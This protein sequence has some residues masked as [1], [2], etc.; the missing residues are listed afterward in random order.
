MKFHYV[1][2]A[3]GLSETQDHAVRSKSNAGNP[4]PVRL[5]DENDLPLPPHPCQY[6]IWNPGGE[7]SFA[8]GLGS[9]TGRRAK[10]LAGASLCHRP[11][12][13]F[14]RARKD[15]I[16]QRSTVLVGAK[17]SYAILHPAEMGNGSFSSP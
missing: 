3:G 14:T 10:C 16:R 13:N 4:T 17:Y 8:Y 2:E 15:V 9:Q 12:R 6:E 11:I 7:V 1:F 5:L